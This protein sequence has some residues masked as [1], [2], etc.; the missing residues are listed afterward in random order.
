[1][2]LFRLHTEDAMKSQVVCMA[3][4]ISKRRDA[5]PAMRASEERFRRVAHTT[6]VLIRAPLQTPA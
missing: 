1:M 5:E 4:D 3:L 2:T 6:P